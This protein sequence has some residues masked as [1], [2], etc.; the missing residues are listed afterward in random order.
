MSAL[1]HA[2][3]ERFFNDP[4]KCNAEGTTTPVPGLPACPQGISAVKAIGLAAAQGQKIYTITQEVYRNNPNIVSSNLSAL[5]YSTQQGIQNA[6]AA[7]NEVTTHERPITQS[8]WTG[9][10]YIFTDPETGAGGYIIDGGSNGGWIPVAAITFTMLAMVLGPLLGALFLVGTTAAAFVGTVVLIGGV[11]YGLTQYIKY[12]NDVIDRPNL[13]IAQKQQLIAAVSVMATIASL[14]AYFKA[15]GDATAA[16]MGLM[17]G[18]LS[19]GF[20]KLEELL[21]GLF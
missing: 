21:W 5:S 2:I 14:F 7:G 1:E 9:A 20:K 18:G 13:S 12:I 6:L 3:P 16:A 4:A 11:I 8:G 17:M 19:A 15:G 10:G